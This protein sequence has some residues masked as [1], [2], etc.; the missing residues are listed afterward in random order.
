MTKQHRDQLDFWEKEE[1]QPKSGMPMRNVIAPCENNW[2]R[3]S[4]TLNVC[5]LA[6]KV[7]VTEAQDGGF[8]R[9]SMPHHDTGP[10]SQLAH[11]GRT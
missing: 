11:A 7:C 10:M 2:D 9:P 8:I 5:N 4:R 6:S 1:S 3:C